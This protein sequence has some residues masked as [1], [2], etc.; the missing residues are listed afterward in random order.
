MLAPAAAI[1]FFIMFLI[2]GFKFVTS[3]GD[4]KAAAS[5]RSTLTY[6]IIGVILVV[7]S[8]LILQLIATITGTNILEVNFT[9]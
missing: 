5:A 3:G 8:W 2:G 1:A 7:G 6:A 9:P 4:P